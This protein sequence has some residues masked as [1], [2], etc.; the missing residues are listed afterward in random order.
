M[1]QLGV[2]RLTRGFFRTVLEEM[3]LDWVSGAQPGPTG[4]TATAPEDSESRRIFL[5][6]RFADKELV[7]IEDAYVEATTFCQQA[8]CHEIRPAGCGATI[9]LRRAAQA[10]RLEK[11]RSEVYPGDRYQSV[12]SV[13]IHPYSAM[14]YAHESAL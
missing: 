4:R 8:V 14:G 9:S 12:L 7:V 3:G 2:V 1:F 13:A 5:G 10:P 6:G 11:T